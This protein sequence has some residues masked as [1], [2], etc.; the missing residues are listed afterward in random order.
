LLFHFAPFL[1]LLAFNWFLRYRDSVIEYG[2]LVRKQLAKRLAPIA[3]E[4][5]RL[6]RAPRTIEQETGSRD[7]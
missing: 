4:H 7:R 1:A 3:P 5:V 2:K 6:K